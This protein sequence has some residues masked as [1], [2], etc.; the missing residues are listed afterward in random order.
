ML[1]STRRIPVAMSALSDT[2][3]E[4]EVRRLGAR[5]FLRKPFDPESLLDAIRQA[6][7]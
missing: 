6:F 7:Q 1:A 5:A 4:R 3:I 2:R